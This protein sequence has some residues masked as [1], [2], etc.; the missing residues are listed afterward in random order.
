MNCKRSFIRTTA[1]ESEI[2]ACPKLTHGLLLLFVLLVRL[3]L[4][5][6]KALGDNLAIGLDIV[7]VGL[8][9]YLEGE[10]ERDS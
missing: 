3:F 7:N 2:N 4:E 10:G 9:P 5:F 6:F 1:K 8:K